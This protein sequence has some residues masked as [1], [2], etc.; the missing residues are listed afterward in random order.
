MPAVVGPQALPQLLV[1]DLL[2]L[3]VER[4]FPKLEEPAKLGEA[5]REVVLLPD[6]VLEQLDTH[7]ERSCLGC[8]DT[9]VADQDRGLAVCREQEERLF[10]ARI[11]TQILNTSEVIARGG[12]A[13]NPQVAVVLPR[14]CLASVTSRRACRR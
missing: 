4:P 3:A 13:V 12:F 14:S 8:A 9:L 10:E 5:W 6:E 11:E 1:G 7:L 2:Q